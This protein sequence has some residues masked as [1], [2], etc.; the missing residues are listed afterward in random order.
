[1]PAAIEIEEWDFRQSRLSWS[2]RWSGSL[3]L[4]KRWM[5]TGCRPRDRAAMTPDLE[6]ANRRSAPTRPS[7][8]KTDAAAYIGHSPGHAEA[9]AKLRS[10][11]DLGSSRFC[12]GHR[13]VNGAAPPLLR[14]RRRL[15]ATYLEG[16]LAPI[17]AL[18]ITKAA[19]PTQKR[20]APRSPL[21]ASEIPTP[22]GLGRGVR[23]S[24]AAASHS[25]RT[26]L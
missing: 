10:P 3:P 5:A 2:K 15:A 9:R 22:I 21:P 7:L 17:E 11:S 24:T 6:Q 16:R 19:P 12:V 18:P 23:Q 13:G 20:E 1:M 26:W 8:F 4:R 14:R 25:M